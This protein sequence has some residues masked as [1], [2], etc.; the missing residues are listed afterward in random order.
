MVKSIYLTPWEQIPEKLVIHDNELAFRFS[1]SYI[2]GIREEFM[3]KNGWFLTFVNATR[4]WQALIL[5]LARKG[6]HLWINEFMEIAYVL[7]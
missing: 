1:G 6:K 2:A 3:S 4:E 7:S 5:V